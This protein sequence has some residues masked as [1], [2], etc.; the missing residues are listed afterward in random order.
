MIVNLHEKG[1]EVIYHRA[2]ALLAAQIAGHWHPELRP[3]RWLETIAAISHHDDLEKEWEGNHLTPA[4]APLDFTLE[5]GV[6]LES[7]RKLTTNAKYRGR[8]VAMLISMHMSF[9]IEGMRGESPEIDEFLDE[10]LK[11]QQQWRK[12]LNITK[13]E[14]AKAYAFFQWCDRMSLILCN[15]EIPEG[16]S[17]VKNSNDFRALEIAKD[18]DGQRYDIHQRSDGNITVTPWAFKE[19][20]FTVRV[21]ASYLDQLQFTDNNELAEALQKAP[22][23]TLEWTFAK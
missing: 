14:A 22:I 3:Q 4:G 5:K 13:D 23:K 7:V 17:S 20:K 2:H 12:E 6:K 11:N 1:W 8:W 18:A 9:L 19:D 15:H 21:E 16:A 10:Q